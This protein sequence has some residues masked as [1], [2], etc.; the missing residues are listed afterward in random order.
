MTVAAGR[1]VWEY[2][3]LLAAAYDHYFG[4]EP[5]WDQDFFADR[6]RANGGRALELA[7]GTGRL[8]VPLL[9][10]GLDVEGLDTSDDMLAI[11]RAKARALK[12]SPALHRLP[13]QEFDLP[14]RYHTVFVPAGTFMILVGDDEVDA[15]LACSLRALEAGGELLIALD[16]D[17]PQPGGDGE[18][19]ERRDVFVPE[20]DARLR[21]LERSHY[22]PATRLTRWQLHYEV[23]RD[24]RP[25]QTF[26]REH[27]LRHHPAAAFRDRLERAGFTKVTV[28]R[29]YTGSPSDEA[30]ADR[31]FSARRP[32][33]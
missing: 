30:D 24:G 10:D 17:E 31:I 8:L 14:S 11:L 6:I 15:T 5:F 22:D 12:L 20:H 19:R 25:P 4:A 33:H 27:L 21:A 3:G 26:D 1:T 16:G 2:S 18:W 28:R 9:R 13:M 23:E 32:S 29:G 7:C